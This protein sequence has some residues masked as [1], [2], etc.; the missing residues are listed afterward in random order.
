LLFLADLVGPLHPNDHS[1]FLQL[2]AAAL[3][4]EQEQIGDGI[5]HRKARELFA[6]F[7]RPPALS[8][9]QPARHERVTPQERSAD[10]VSFRS[11]RPNRHWVSGNSPAKRDR[12]TIEVG[13]ASF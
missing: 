3:R 5:L 11:A 12:L 1:A 7:F 8:A 9:P 6:R 2:L 13:G 4:Y 10:R